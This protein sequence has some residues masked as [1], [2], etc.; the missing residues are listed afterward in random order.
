MNRKP[1]IESRLVRIETLL[2]EIL[3]ALAGDRP[4]GRYEYERALKAFAAGDRRP[5]ELY[6]KRGGRP[7]G[8][9]S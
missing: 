3:G 1:D 9:G 7:I 4:P 2:E 8:G 5:L 6:L